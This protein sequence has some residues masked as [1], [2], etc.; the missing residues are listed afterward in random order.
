MKKAKVVALNVHDYCKENGI[1]IGDY[2]IEELDKVAEDLDGDMRLCTAI[3][4][5]FKK[6]DLETAVHVSELKDIYVI[7]SG[8]P[9]VNVAYVKYIKGLSEFKELGKTIYDIERKYL[10]SK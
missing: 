8:N 4:M 5:G 1:K 6:V 7:F 2:T 9:K 3:L 10:M